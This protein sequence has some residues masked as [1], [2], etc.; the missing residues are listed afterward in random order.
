MVYSVLGQL[1][2]DPRSPDQAHLLMATSRP[3]KGTLEH[4]LQLAIFLW[5]VDRLFSIPQSF[6]TIGGGDGLSGEVWLG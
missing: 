4:L 2:K 3:E 5:W 1:T 6:G